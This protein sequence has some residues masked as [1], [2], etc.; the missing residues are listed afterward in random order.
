[1]SMCMCDRVSQATNFIKRPIE[2]DAS[3]RH[4]YNVVCKFSD[5]KR[6]DLSIIDLHKQRFLLHT[7][8][9]LLTNRVFVAIVRS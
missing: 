2:G 3:L 4:T 8:G 1:M 5:E 6:D 9:L 7:I